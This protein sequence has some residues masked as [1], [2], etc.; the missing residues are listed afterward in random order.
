MMGEYLILVIDNG[1]DINNN[2]H[3]KILKKYIEPKY[4]NYVIPEYSFIVVKNNT[5]KITEQ[6]NK[7][8]IVFPDMKI[9]IQYSTNDNISDIWSN[10]MKIYSHHI[11]MSDMLY[12]K[13]IK[14][15]RPSFINY[16]YELFNYFD[17]CKIYDY[18]LV[19]M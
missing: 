17:L 4:R 6:I 2:L 5:I 14:L 13:H 7:H 1:F 18:S 16:P 3:Y 11:F 15:F 10:I 9:L 19:L 12:G 8:K